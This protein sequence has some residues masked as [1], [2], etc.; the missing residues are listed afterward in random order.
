[1]PLSADTIAAATGGRLIAGDGDHY[2]TGFST[3]TRTLASGDLFF[4]IV[5]ARDGHGFVGAA[6]KRRAAGLVVSKAIA[7]P[8]DHES[9]VIEVADTTRALQD[10]GR[11]VRR[12]SKA[13]V[14]AIPAAPARRDKDAIAELLKAK[15]R[16]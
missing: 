10:L 1:M 14:V 16:W 11:F 3:D 5:A 8:E 13:K 7:I 9:F 2:V 12:A 15:C 6:F 4:A